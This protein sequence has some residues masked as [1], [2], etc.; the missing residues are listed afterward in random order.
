[1]FLV[2]DVSAPGV[3]RVVDH[4]AVLQ[5]AMVILDEMGEP[6]RDREEAGALRRQV[7][8]VGVCPSDDHRELSQRP[9]RRLLPR[10]SA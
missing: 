9:R 1:M 10:D 3:Q 7:Q 4:E 6:E 5:L 8:P 2:A